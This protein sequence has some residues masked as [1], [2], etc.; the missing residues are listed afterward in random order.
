MNTVADL[1]VL[2]LLD[3]VQFAG[4]ERHVLQL[5]SGLLRAGA[6]VTLMCR[7][8]GVLEA[9]G[10][11]AGIRVVGVPADAGV[12][13]W[14]RAVLNAVTRHRPSVVHGHNG[15]TMLIAAAVGRFTGVAAVG[16][17]HFLDPQFVNYPPLKRLVARRAHEWVNDGLRRVICVAAAAADSMRRRE[18]VSARKLAVV[19]NGIDPPSPPSAARL[20]SL[21]RE[22]GAV[23]GR[24]V[25]T[26]V[27]RLEPEKGVEVLIRAFAE[28]RRA[29]PDLILVIIGD[30]S[31]RSSLE[32]LAEDLGVGRHVRFTGFR[33]DA[34]DLIACG[35]I[36]A[37][38]SPAEPFGLVLLEAMAHRKPVVACDSGGP[39]EIVR[40]GQTGYLV[41][42]SDVPA[43]GAR[44]ADLA[45]NESLRD[46]IGRA[47]VEVFEREFT[48]ERMV[49]KTLAVYG[50]ATASKPR[51]QTTG[52]PISA[53]AESKP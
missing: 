10:Q 2:L 48:A 8:D 51:G 22:L 53:V 50:A 20:A 7:A 18:R 43:M 45:M 33:T 27:A 52:W 44:T 28:A 19:W 24:P 29:V 35:D 41:P 32:A 3:T 15:R 12:F 17:Q 34:T 47:A 9:A 5:A 30:G 40:D 13:G 42:P 16:T 6:G 1:H 11:R 38:P 14:F 4:T 39:R 26:C 46:R 25:V 37:L 49:A 36:F 31:L 23:P 21:R